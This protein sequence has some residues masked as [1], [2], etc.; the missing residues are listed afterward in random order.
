MP[1]N[2]AFASLCLIVITSVL[3]PSAS[4]AQNYATSANQ[5]QGE[6]Q[7]SR[8]APAL[9]GG[10]QSNVETGQSLN[11]NGLAAVNLAGLD[12]Q[13]GSSFS[14]GETAPLG[15]L[16]WLTTDAERPYYGNSR[17]SPFTISNRPSVRV[18][19]I[20]HPD[21]MAFLE[22]AASALG[23]VWSEVATCSDPS[24][25]VTLGTYYV[26]LPP[27]VRV[28]RLIFSHQSLWSYNNRFP[29]SERPSLFQA[30][31]SGTAFFRGQADFLIVFGRDGSVRAN[32]IPTLVPGIYR[33]IPPTIPPAYGNCMQRSLETLSGH[34]A[35]TWPA[36]YPKSEII[37]RLHCI[38]PKAGLLVYEDPK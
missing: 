23:Q 26:Q 37:C 30:P 9:Q 38:T 34:P 36:N 2:R 12:N 3:M 17:T 21:M 6:A 16:N 11:A 27:G 7:Y 33:A 35:F 5:W 22:D 10:V 14:Y 31:G 1:I 29:M 13:G 20:N 28:P 15:S 8:N 4:F 18:T 25:T 32:Q 24:Q 19:S